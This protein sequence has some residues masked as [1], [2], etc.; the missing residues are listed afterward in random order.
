[1]FQNIYQ[2]KYKLSNIISHLKGA[3]IAP[4]LSP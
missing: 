4:Y 1:M 3:V 2:S